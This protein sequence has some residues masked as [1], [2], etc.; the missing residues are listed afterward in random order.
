MPS[1]TVE[2]WRKIHDTNRIERTPAILI[3]DGVWVEIQ[4]TRD[5]FKEDRS[6]H[7]RQSRQ[8]EERVIL[9]ALAVWEDGSYE[10]LHYEI[11][12]EEGEAEWSTFFG[13]LIERGLQAKKVQLVVSDGSVGLSKALKAHLPEAQ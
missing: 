13:N 7:L 12:V 4:Y 3:V 6:G 2:L 1:M 8:A 5:E 11:A 10:I 9:A